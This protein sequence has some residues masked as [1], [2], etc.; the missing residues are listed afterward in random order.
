[1]HDERLVTLRRTVRRRQQVADFTG[2]RPQIKLGRSAFGDADREFA[3]AGLHGHAPVDG[4]RDGDVARSCL[5]VDVTVQS[6]DRQRT[7]RSTK[8]HF[9]V[10]VADRGVPGGR[11]HRCRIR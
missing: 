4:G 10:E 2:P 11:G 1:M 5:R 3:A 8:L 7:A 9:A 6:P